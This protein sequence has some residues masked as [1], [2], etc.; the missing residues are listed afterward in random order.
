[1]ANGDVTVTSGYYYGGSSA[2]TN[3]QTALNN[4]VSGFSKKQ[5]RGSIRLS[6]GSI[7]FHDKYGF[8]F[9]EN[10]SQITALKLSGYKTES[11][12][13]NSNSST[14]AT[15]YSIPANSFA[16]LDFSKVD[17]TANYYDPTFR[18]IKAVLPYSLS[19]KLITFNGHFSSTTLEVSRTSTSPIKD[20]ISCSI[21]VYNPTSAAVSVT[22]SHSL[23]VYCYAIGSGNF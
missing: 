1:M 11:A 10:V 7:K 12:M 4:V 3:L 8:Y 17:T 6:C 16:V 2:T 22:S 9:S 13:T 23:F 14:R 18:I 5:D 15:S 20:T 19:A 21:T